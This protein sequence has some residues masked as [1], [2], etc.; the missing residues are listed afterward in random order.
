MRRELDRFDELAVDD[1]LLPIDFLDDDHTS[2]LY[3]DALLALDGGQFLRLR[4]IALALRAPL[5][6]PAEAHTA[7]R[8]SILR[9]QWAAAHPMPGERRSCS[10][11]LPP[12]EICRVRPAGFR[13]CVTPRYVFSAP[14]HPSRRLDR[15][16][17]LETQS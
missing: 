14:W 2:S 17:Q 11:F 6:V 9:L 12:L 13:S 8:R 5:R 10:G 15:E 16:S 4:P 1:D 3:R 7:Y